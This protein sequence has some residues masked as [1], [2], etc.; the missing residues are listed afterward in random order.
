MSVA[1]ILCSLQ[2]LSSATAIEQLLG[3]VL[4]MPYAKRRARESLN[5]AY[6]HVCE[7]TFA[8]AAGALVD[9]SGP[10]PAAPFLSVFP[11]VAHPYEGYSRSH[12]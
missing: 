10:D 8:Q 3:R 6:A 1:Y 4:R 2:P 9:G 12:D 7:A 5:R 11:Y